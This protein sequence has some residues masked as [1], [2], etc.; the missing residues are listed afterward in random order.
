MGHCKNKSLQQAEWNL[1]KTKSFVIL[2]LII[3]FSQ[4]VTNEKTA[5]KGESMWYMCCSE[6]M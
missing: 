4:T 5:K 2:Y 3:M 1:Y 6:D